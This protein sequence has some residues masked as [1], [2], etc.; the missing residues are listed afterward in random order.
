MNRAPLLLAAKAG[1]S[2]LLVAVVVRYLDVDQ[3]MQRLRASDLDFVLVGYGLVAIVIALSGWRWFIL[4]NGLLDWGQAMRYTWIGAFFGHILPGGVS[5]DIAKGVSIALKH[6]ETRDLTLPASIVVD[7][8]IGFIVLVVLFALACMALFASGAATESMRTGVVALLAVSVAGLGAMSVGLWLVATGLADKIVERV[9]LSATGVGRLGHKVTESLR[10]YARAPALLWKA[11]GISFAIHACNTVL[12]YATLR[13]VG[14]E[15]PLLL[16]LVAYPILS[17]AVML[18]ITVSGIG[19][20]EIVMIGCF[21]I[22]GLGK[23]AA[24]A[25]AWLAILMA[26]PIVILGALIQ[27]R[28]VFARRARSVHPPHA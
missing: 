21:A 13:A 10:Q 5:G 25:Q 8:L 4:A 19:V 20:R 27:L 9:G 3:V 17:V 6:P 22:F 23:E 18:P 26:V 28:E 1:I 11:A 2:A 7:K 16:P 24:V 15:P 12:L 14:V